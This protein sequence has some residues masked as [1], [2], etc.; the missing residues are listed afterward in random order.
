VGNIYDIDAP[1]LE[2]LFGDSDL[3]TEKVQKMNACEWIEI[4]LPGMSWQDCS[5]TQKWHSSVW[6]EID[7]SEYIWERKTSDNS[8]GAGHIQIEDEDQP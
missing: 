6:V 4:E 7:D 3:I 8:I 1:G 2:N 5:V